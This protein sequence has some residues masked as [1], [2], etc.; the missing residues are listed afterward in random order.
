MAYISLKHNTANS[1]M[2]R[3]YWTCLTYEKRLAA[4]QHRPHCNVEWMTASKH[5]VITSLQRI[6]DF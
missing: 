4:V 5:C 3:V 6:C 2:I 1:V